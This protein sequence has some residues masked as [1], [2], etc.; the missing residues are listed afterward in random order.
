[1]VI[2]LETEIVVVGGGPAGLAAALAVRQK[3]FEVCVVDR[4]Q[5]PTDKA[6]GEGVMPDGVTALSRLG[7]CLGVDHGVPFR[8]I[9][10]VG[11]QRIAEASFP[12]GSGIGIRRTAL[13]HI[14]QDRARAAGIVTAWGMKVT[15]VDPE[16]VRLRD[17]L[18][19]CRWIIAA[20]GSVSQIRQWAGL[21]PI[22]QDGGRIGLRQHFR[23]KPWSDFVEVHWANG[24]QAYVTPVGP[25]EVCI[26]LLSRER[27]LRFTELAAHFPQLG[28]H[29]KNAEPTDAVRGGKVASVHLRRVTCGRIALIGDAS[30]SI[31]AVTGE[32]LTLAFR[33]AEAL[34]A[35]LAEND[36]SSYEAAHRRI[37]RMPFFMARL[38]LL[39][40]EHHGLRKIG[41]QA[42]ASQ[43]GTF[44]R[45]LA[46]H[47]G[48]RHPAAASLDIL[49]LTVGLLTHAV[50]LHAV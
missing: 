4:A 39:M 30:S 17:Q 31:D 5:P 18:I 33:Q 35:A 9:R 49:A 6:C 46:A 15:G 10:F 28:R 2:P 37:C 45:L 27:E 41:L 19:R 32:G 12:R 25:E 50:T 8:G 36:L 24:C 22:R 38:L 26:A 34:A 43:P 14:L 21:S 44:S 16:G 42:L 3:G 20:D 11:D 47:V 7:V 23:I 40:D 48:A 1:M 29:L 13:H